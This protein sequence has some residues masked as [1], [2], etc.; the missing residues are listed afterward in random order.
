MFDF[1]QIID[2]AAEEIEVSIGV[3]V[4]PAARYQLLER[5]RQHQDDVQKQITQNN[6]RPDDLV[7]AA[8]RQLAEA[9]RIQKPSFRLETFRGI[10]VGKMSGITIDASDVSAGME[11]RC[12]W[13][14][15]C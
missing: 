5:L 8:R 15:W 3:S 6:L 14:P 7:E 11:R 13:I 9:V 12:W 10:D 1:Q 2:R 4:T